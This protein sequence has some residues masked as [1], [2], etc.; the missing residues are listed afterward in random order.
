MLEGEREM[1]MESDVSMISQFRRRLR[2][3]DSSPFG[4]KGG[5]MFLRAG[6]LS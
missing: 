5:F 1:R 3:V 2:N 6:D 4:C